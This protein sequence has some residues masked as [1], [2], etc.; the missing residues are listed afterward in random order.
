ML[1]FFRFIRFLTIT[2][3]FGKPKNAQQQKLLEMQA[4]GS[5]YASGGDKNAYLAFLPFDSFPLGF[6]RYIRRSELTS[7]IMNKSK[8]PA[9]RSWDSQPNGT[10][11]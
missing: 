11:S 10:I 8:N 1:R 2:H 3:K 5:F 7:L 4:R 6:I 9:E